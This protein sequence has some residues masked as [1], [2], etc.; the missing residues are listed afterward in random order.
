MRRDYAGLHQLKMCRFRPDR[1]LR[2]NALPAVQVGFKVHFAGEREHIVTETRS[3]RCFRAVGAKNK[4]FP[5]ILVPQ[6]RMHSDELA[7][8]LNAFFVVE[9]NKIHSFLP[10]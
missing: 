6:I 1:L 4:L 7:H 2:S 9:Y 10:E 5:D 3:Q 8:H